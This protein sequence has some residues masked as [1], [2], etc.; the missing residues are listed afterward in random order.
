MERRSRLSLKCP[1]DGDVKFLADRMLGTLTRY[2]RFMGYD[3]ISANNIPAGDRRE[4]T[5]LLEQ[6][7]DECR[8]LLTRDRELAHRGGNDAVW[9]ESEKIREQVR[10]LAARDLIHPVL[11]MNRCSLCNQPLRPATEDEIEQTDYGPRDREGLAF[12][13]CPR[14]RKLYWIGSH[15]V[16]L[17]RRLEEFLSRE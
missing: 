7:K 17:T 3:T 16:G 4:D 5:V 1:P 15:S 13:W 6:A 2:L 9:I 10:Q 8:I 12:Y 11:R 14:C